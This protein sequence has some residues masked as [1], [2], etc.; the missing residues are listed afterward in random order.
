MPYY[1]YSN[2]DNE[3]EIIE[4]FQHM[5][6]KHEFIVDGIIWNRVWTK[7]Q[8]SVDMSWDSMDM[9]K[10]VE[11]TGK[12]KGT[13]GDMYDT[14]AA[15]SQARVDKI[16]HDPIREKKLEQWSKERGGRKFVDTKAKKEQV[17]EI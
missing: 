7:P 17:F 14:A 12:M 6:D 16:G 11:K 3:N 8:A 2:P 5:N 13:M 15:L 1:L 9:K 4:V 10:C